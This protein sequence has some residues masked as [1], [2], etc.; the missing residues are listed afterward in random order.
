VDADRLPSHGG[1]VTLAHRKVSHFSRAGPILAVMVLG[2]K[3]GVPPHE[4]VPHL[5]TTGMS[6]ACLHWH[7]QWSLL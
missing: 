3:E 4:V 2:V 5:L 6:H 1:T 7:W